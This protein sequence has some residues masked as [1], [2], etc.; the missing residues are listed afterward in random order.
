MD[1]LDRILK[2]MENNQMTQA[3]L[4]RA[5]EVRS[6]SVSDWTKRK[7]T[8][9]TKYL[10]R[11]A[12][13]FNVS[14]DYLITGEENNADKKPKLNAKDEKDIAKDLAA[15][16]EKLLNKEDGP[17]SFDGENVSEES[18]ELLLTQIEA[19]LR[20]IKVINK[21]KYNPNKNKK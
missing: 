2:L 21:E 3:D 1:T 17:A 11:I 13:H 19:M 7:S 18:A 8:S 12:K 9:Y 20:T 5:L 4:A 10:D 15:M 16:R 6:S 14:V